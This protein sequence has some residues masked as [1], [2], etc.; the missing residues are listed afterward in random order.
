MFIDL[1]KAKNEFLNYTSNYDKNNS[2]IDLK[3]WHSIRV[4]ELSK[5]LGERMDL[6]EEDI[7]IATVIG[8]LHDLGRFDQITKHDTFNDFQSFDHGDYAVELLNNDMRNYVDTDKYDDLIK[9]AI[10][11][12]NKYKIEDG[13]TEK[14]LLF[15]KLVRDADKVDILYQA[16][17]RYWEGKEE[18]INNSLIDQKILDEFF[19]K[20]QVEFEHEKTYNELAEVIMTIAFIF[21][22]NFKESFQVIKNENYINKILD[23]FNFK[24]IDKIREFANNYIDE[25]IQEA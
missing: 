21:D 4:M 17:Y 2:K 15:S 6:D 1:R 10:K 25:K 11:N 12:H 19:D 7:E 22:I 20:K 8:L 24:D 14:E 18:K 9:V 13:L 5:L 3:I 16:T 23:R